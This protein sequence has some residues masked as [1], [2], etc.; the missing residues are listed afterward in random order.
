MRTE[1][2][3]LNLLLQVAKTLKVEAVA[4][5]GSRAEGQAPKDEFQDYDVVYI[6]D[7][8]D[9]LTSDLA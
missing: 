4:L 1:T 9:N 5:S 8:L 7:D 6:V 3:I 2:E